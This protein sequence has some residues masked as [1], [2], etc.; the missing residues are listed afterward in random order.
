MTKSK[1]ADLTPKQ[2]WDTL[3]AMR[4]P[5][6]HSSEPIKWFTTAV[7]RGAMRSVMRVGGTV[8][9]DCNLIIVPSK[10]GRTRSG[11]KSTI[12]PIW[13]GVN[14]QHFFQ[15]VYEA[16]EVLDIPRCDYPDPKWWEI[17]GKAI[18]G[19]QLYLPVTLAKGIERECP[20]AFEELKRH[21]ESYHGVEWEKVE[22]IKGGSYGWPE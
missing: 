8:N 6:A 5:D 21:I 22:E 13:Q 16:A 20:E 7:I 9:S 4:G 10:W 14:W 12:P 3:V 17:M 2:Q 1:W 15:H 18:Y 19:N 11:E